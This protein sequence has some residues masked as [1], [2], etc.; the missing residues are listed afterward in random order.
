MLVYGNHF[1]CNQRLLVNETRKNNR[2]QYFNLIYLN[3][4]LF[5]N[6]KEITIYDQLVKENL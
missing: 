6:Q 4:F 3:I 1:E 2:F 5:V